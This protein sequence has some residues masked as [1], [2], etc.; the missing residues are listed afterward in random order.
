MDLGIGRAVQLA[1]WASWTDHAIQVVHLASWTD[2]TVQLV[3]LAS[4]TNSYC[5]G[6]DLVPFTEPWRINP[7]F[8]IDR[9]R[10]WSFTIRTAKIRFPE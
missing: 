4:W 9:S 1:K 8:R 3:H 7:S 6:L 10:H 5:R 2:H